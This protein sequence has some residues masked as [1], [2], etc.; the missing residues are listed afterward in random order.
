ML[1]FQLEF[2]CDW[3]KHQTNSSGLP[4]GG[5]EFGP[6]GAPGAKAMPSVVKAKL[7]PPLPL[8]FQRR[9]V[10]FW[11][12]CTGSGEMMTVAV[13]PLTVM[14]WMLTGRS[15]PEGHSEAK[16]GLDAPAMGGGV[17]GASGLPHAA[18]TARQIAAGMRLLVACMFFLQMGLVATDVRRMRRMRRKSCKRCATPSASGH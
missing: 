14:L 9:P 18:R 11:P 7:L 12:I 4:V 8:S 2:G 15:G 5:A 3:P 6:L 13:E 17:A 10:A 16:A 1:Y